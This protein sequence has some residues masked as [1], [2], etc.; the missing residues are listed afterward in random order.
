M[1]LCLVAAAESLEMRGI[2]P[3]VGHVVIA[4]RQIA[5]ALDIPS[6]ILSSLPRSRNGISC[7]IHGLRLSLHTHWPHT[8]SYAL[9]NACEKNQLGGRL[10][11]TLACSFLSASKQCSVHG[12]CVPG[13][14]AV[15]GRDHPT[16]DCTPYMHAITPYACEVGDLSGKLGLISAPR[17]NITYENTLAISASELHGRAMSFQCTS[18]DA[19]A[20]CA[21]LVPSAKT[22]VSPP[23]GPWAP[24]LQPPAQPPSP[25]V[26]IISTE[27]GI[28]G[29]ARF[30]AGMA[31]F[32]FDF[33]GVDLTSLPGGKGCIEHGIQYHVHHTAAPSLGDEAAGPMCDASQAGGL[34]DPGLVCSAGSGNV[35]CHNNGGCVE[36]A[37]DEAAL[38]CHTSGGA[39][40]CQ[41][42]DLSGK[43]GNMIISLEGYTN[44]QLTEP[45]MPPPEMKRLMLVLRCGKSGE[46]LLCSRLQH[47][48]VL[49]QEARHD[50][51]QTATWDTYLQIGG[52]VLLLVC[53]GIAMFQA[54]TLM[55]RLV[56]H[57]NEADCVQYAAC[58]QNAASIID[59]DHNDDIEGL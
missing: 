51:H 30:A 24:P 54:C 55:R 23:L 4:D 13:S 37:W 5:I 27:E 9:G 40:V 25:L 46:V 33:S 41:A 45:S 52:G 16:Y 14:S 36:R 38:P 43:H 2:V 10:D 17:A 47:E 53:C 35:L 12:G 1:T 19:Y 21:L 59:E 32:S 26:A 34:Y 6:A 44:M 11:P 22:S 28:R 8:S 31:N 18:S 57:G 56:L 15:S 20:F 29:S 58:D 42:G 49:Q 7:H 3:R 48:A 50:P 39:T